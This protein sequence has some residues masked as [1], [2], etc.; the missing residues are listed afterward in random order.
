[1]T[2][3]LSRLAAGENLITIVSAPLECEKH[4]VSTVV[5]TRDVC[6]GLSTQLAVPSLCI[7]LWGWSQSD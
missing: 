7:A 2:L 6:V 3:Y 4:H 1:M 5:G